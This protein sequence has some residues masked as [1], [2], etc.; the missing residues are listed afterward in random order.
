[1]AVIPLLFN[2]WWDDYDYP[3]V[4]AQPSLWGHPHQHHHH[5]R[6]TIICAT[7]SRPQQ[8]QQTQN[9]K[10]AERKEDKNKFEVILDVQQ[11][12][13][14]EINVKVVDGYIVVEGNHEEKQDDHG[15]VSRQFCRRYK[16]PKD[17][18][19]DTIRPS[20]SSDGVLTLR[21]PLKSVEP[22]KPQER[23]VPIE[24]TGKPAKKEEPKKVEEKKK[25]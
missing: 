12:A 20:L 18:D 19:P 2:N 11:F 24:Q 13:P 4:A 1:M 16:I 10:V 9:G 7:Y 22:P 3:F 21:A 25:A 17:V 5:Q 23:V 6:P 14:N 8:Q 15:F